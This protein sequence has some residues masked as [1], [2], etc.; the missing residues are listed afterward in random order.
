VIPLPHNPRPA[1]IRD[2]ELCAA[3]PLP[4]RIWDTHM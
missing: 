1:R 3:Q 4:L 2:F